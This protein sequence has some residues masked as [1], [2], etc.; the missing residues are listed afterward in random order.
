M[1]RIKSILWGAGL[2]ALIVDAAIRC[3]QYA[4]SHSRDL[5]INIIVREELDRALRSVA[6]RSYRAGYEDGRG[7]VGE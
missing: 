1:D 4:D 7:A 2:A 3:A 6:E 5:P